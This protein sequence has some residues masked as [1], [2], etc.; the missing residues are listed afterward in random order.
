ME[1]FGAAVIDADAISRSTTQAGGVAMPDIAKQFGPAFVS[2]DGA[3]NRVKMREHI[4]AEPAARAR[5]EAIIHPL[6]AHAIRCKILAAHAKCLVFDV[7][8]LVE[9]PSWRHQLDLVWVVDCSQA[10]QIARVGTR[11][12]WS[13]RSTKAVID[14]QSTRSV[15]AAAA[16]AVLFNERLNLTELKGLVKQLAGQFG[17]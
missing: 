13:E 16:D 14:S 11:S 15:R 4:F 10:T 5:L 17:L 7:P 3:L 6:V 9:S 2:D 8:L 12:G 1:S